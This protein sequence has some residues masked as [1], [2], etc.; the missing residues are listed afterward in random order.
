MNS[1]S[2]IIKFKPRNKFK[3]EPECISLL[4]AVTEHV[5]RL[6]DADITAFQNRY[7]VGDDGK[8]HSCEDIL[9][10]LGNVLIRMSKKI[11]RNENE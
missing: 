7:C 2:K 4:I 10:Q 3:S 8:R 6:M 5:L 9:W 1:M 11:E